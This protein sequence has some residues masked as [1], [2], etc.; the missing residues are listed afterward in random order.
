MN[1]YDVQLYILPC[2]NEIRNF[3]E[4]ENLLFNRHMCTNN[5]NNRL[6]YK[7]DF[8]EDNQNKM[9]SINWNYFQEFE[10]KYKNCKNINMIYQIYIIVAKILNKSIE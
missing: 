3:Y 6:T 10:Q 1:I 2:S 8:I 5:I 7:C 9:R 4:P